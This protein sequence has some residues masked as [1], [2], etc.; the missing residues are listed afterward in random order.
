VGLPT[1]EVPACFGA[2]GG[3]E[4]HRSPLTIAGAGVCDNCTSL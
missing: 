2:N 1:K 3:V 4:C